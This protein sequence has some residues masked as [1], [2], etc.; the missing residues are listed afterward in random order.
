MVT[1]L[2]HGILCCGPRAIA[3]SLIIPSLTGDLGAVPLRESNSHCLE[4]VID[5]LCMHISHMYYNNLELKYWDCC[6][7]FKELEVPF[8]CLLEDFEKV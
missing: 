3:V 7:Y 4:S 2:D 1:V 5:I 6:K 8:T